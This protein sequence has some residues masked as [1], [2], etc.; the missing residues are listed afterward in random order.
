MDNIGG[1]L[2]NLERKISLVEVDVTNFKDKER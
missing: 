1:K 2:E